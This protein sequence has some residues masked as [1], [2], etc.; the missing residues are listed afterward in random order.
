MTPTQF[1]DAMQANLG[2]VISQTAHIETEVYKIKYPDLDYASLVPVDSSANPFAKSVTYFSMDQAGEAGWINGNGKDVPI[3]GTSMEKHETAVYS[4]GVGYSFGF[5]EVNQAR[6]LGVSLESEMA[7]AARRAYEQMV[8]SIAFT[9]DTTKGFTGLF[10]AAGVTAASV[11]A[12][13]TA[14]ATEWSAKTPNLIL[15]DVNE[16]IISIHNTT[17][18]VEIADTVLLPY[19]SFNYIASTPR[20]DNSDMTILEYLL[21][22]NVYTANTGQQLTIRGHR[23]LETAGAGSVKRM[24]AYRRSPEVLKLHIPMPHQFFPVQV[25]G[26]QFTVPGMFRLGGLDVRLPKAVIYRDGI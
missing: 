12:D 5:E 4:A 11:A 1:N 23:D 26:F 13:G 6:M 15:R 7:S 14:S 24:V 16:A 21:R 17:K 25:E 19:T 22:S 9:G 2:F 3:V 8:Y 10:N 18:T 20:S